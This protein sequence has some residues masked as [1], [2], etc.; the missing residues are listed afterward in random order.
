[1]GRPHPDTFEIRNIRVL[2]HQAM[3]QSASAKIQLLEFVAGILQLQRGHQIRI[4]YEGRGQSL[5]RDSD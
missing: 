5:A 4:E 2:V 3:V 1:M